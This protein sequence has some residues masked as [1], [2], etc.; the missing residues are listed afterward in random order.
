MEGMEDREGRWEGGAVFTV[1][2]S[3]TE[4]KKF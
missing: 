2:K 3:D 1:K 4:L